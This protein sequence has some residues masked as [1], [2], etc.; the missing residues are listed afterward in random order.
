MVAEM[1]CIYADFGNCKMKNA[2]FIILKLW[3]IMRHSFVFEIASKTLQVILG[4]SFH[5]EMRT[6]A[7]SC[8][9]F[10][11]VLL[12][13]TKMKKMEAFDHKYDEPLAQC[14]SNYIKH[15]DEMATTTITWTGTRYSCCKR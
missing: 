4:A 12:K 13:H 11:N 1:M 9:T 6:H 3:W 5:A 15:E 2:S 10:D 14:I 7:N 8:V